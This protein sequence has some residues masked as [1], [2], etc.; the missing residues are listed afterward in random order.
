MVIIILLHS[1]QC[2][3]HQRAEGNFIMNGHLGKNLAIYLDIGRMNSVHQLAVAHAMHT[4]SSVDA[5]NPQPAH[6]TLAITAGA[7]HK[8]Q[9]AAEPTTARIGNAEARPTTTWRAR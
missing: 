1:L 5:C 8:R 3:F 7:T 9:R 4:C 6:I 2:S